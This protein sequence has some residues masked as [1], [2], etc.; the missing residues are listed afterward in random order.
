MGYDMS[1]KGDIAPADPHEVNQARSAW[2][3]AADLHRARMDADR[4]ANTFTR[5]RHG[6]SA[7]DTDALYE[8]YAA[9]AYA[10]DFRLNIF[11]MSRYRTAMFELG[12]M[13]A[14]TY[15]VSSDEWETLPEY[16]DDSDEAAYYEAKDKLTA[17][18]GDSTLPTLPSH[19]FGSNDG[20]LVTP[21]EIRAALAKWDEWNSEDH[22][23]VDAEVTEVISSDY[24]GKWIAYLRLAADHDGFRVH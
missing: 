7:K 16:E 1:I 6:E 20:W 5:D 2:N 22:Q 14:S 18:H 3:Q 13:H 21:D 19:K 17:R 12:M 11:G 10:G 8:K 24:W 9:L 15:P 23:D 4:A